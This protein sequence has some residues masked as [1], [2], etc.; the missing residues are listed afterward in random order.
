MGKKEKSISVIN[1]RRFIQSTGAA[2]A[3]VG[4]GGVF[5]GALSS[6]RPPNVILLVAD[7]LG[8]RDLGC[9]GNEGVQTP[10][11]DEMASQGVRFTNAFVTAPSCSPSRASIMTGQASHSVGVHGL[12][13][14][15]RRFQMEP[16]IPTMAGQLRETGYQ[17]G[18]G[19]KWHAAPFKSRTHYGYNR[20]LSY[21]FVKK[22]HRACRYISRYK[23]QPF[24]LELNF[25]QT[26]RDNKGRFEM[27]KDF[28]VDP[29][30]IHVPNYW[31]LPDLPAIREDVAKY[32]SQA[33]RMDYIIGEIL[34]RLERENI[35]DR[36]LVMFV[37]DNGPPYPGCKTTCY[38]R[39]IGAPL[40]LRWPNA[41]PRGKVIDSLVS[42]TDLM[43][44]ALDAAGVSVPEPVQGKSLLP[45]IGGKTDGLHDAVFAEVTYHVKYTPMRA[46]RTPEWKYIRNF[47]SKPTGL[48]QNKDFEWAQKVAELP[49]QKCCV[50]RPPEELFH[51]AKD[52]NE[53]NNLAD[54]PEYA[55]VKSKLK[56]RLEKWR[57][58]TADPFPHIEKK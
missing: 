13:H 12:T 23:D 52:P 49:G 38:D 24:F 22:P 4:F 20:H 16:E 30:S 14:L 39:G 29:D 37:S 45:L 15:H 26:H 33:A 8:W 55:D 5:S 7:D 3:A 58:E 28:P 18:I 42:T 27:D 1:R 32:Y 36:T 41:L 51:V 19:G 31:A 21:F 10:N 6:E 11:L 53:G 34:D 44:T 54:D 2:A 56:E 9:Y 17:T 46:V 43:P 57:E 25:F 40:I 50:P 35:A 47:N 48:D